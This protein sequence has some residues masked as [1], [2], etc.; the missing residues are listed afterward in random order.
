MINIF[1]KSKKK[2]KKNGKPAS[3]QVQ[4]VMLVDASQTGLCS[5]GKCPHALCQWG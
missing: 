5:Q 2:K 3:I 4:P 1:K